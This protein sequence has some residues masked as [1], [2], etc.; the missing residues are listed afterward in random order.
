MRWCHDELTLDD[1]LADPLIESLMRADGV[2]ADALR[3]ALSEIA[4]L[5]SARENDDL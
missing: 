2:D 4:E 3:P 1:M 5:V